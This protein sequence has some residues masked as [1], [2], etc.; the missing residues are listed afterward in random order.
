MSNFVIAAG[1]TASEILGVELLQNLMKAD[2]Q[3]KFP[4]LWERN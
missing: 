3:E 4:N 1:H 2:V